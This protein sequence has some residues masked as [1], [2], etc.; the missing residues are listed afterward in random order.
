MCKLVSGAE[1]RLYAPLAALLAAQGRI[2]CGAL[3]LEHFPIV[4]VICAG[5]V[6]A[7]T[8]LW[9]FKVHNLLTIPL[10]LSGVVFHAVSDGWSGAGGSLLG[11]LFGFVVLLVPYLIGGLGAGDV[12]LMA[13]VGAW[14]GMPATFYVFAISS[15]AAGVYGLILVLTNGSARE[16]W[17]RLQILCYQ[18]LTMFRYLGTEERIETAVERVDRR[19]LIPF[20]AMMPIGI[21]V[22]IAWRWL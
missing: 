21:G 17:V 12:K 4:V 19:R 20:A 2:R 1:R 16:L 10:L 11:L 7:V 15:I 14:L 9:K 6:A 8:D 22:F 5:I 13:G 18:C 3:M